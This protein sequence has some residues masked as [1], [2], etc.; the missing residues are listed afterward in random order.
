MNVEDCDVKTEYKHVG[1]SLEVL[2]VVLADGTI[3]LAVT[4]RV[5]SITGEKTLGNTTAP[6]IEERKE[7]TM[8]FLD[9]GEVMVIG[10][11]MTDRE[12][13]SSSRVPVLWQIPLF[14][15]LFRSEKKSTERSTVNVMLRAVLVEDSVMSGMDSRSADAVR[16]IW[17]QSRLEN[18]N[19]AP[20]P[21]GKIGKDDVDFILN[22]W[23]NETG[24]SVPD[25]AEVNTPAFPQAPP[26]KKGSQKW[27]PPTE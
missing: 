6:I 25:D 27:V 3:Q 18:P 24:L 10:G 26:T 5:S 15:E 1:I 4:P 19:M 9:P 8:V 12:I 7:S 21:A 16:D 13:R 14:G 11:L 17:E 2:P 20:A 22:Q 23:R